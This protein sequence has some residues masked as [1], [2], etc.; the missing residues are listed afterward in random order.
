MAEG[1]KL[2][3]HFPFDDFDKFFDRSRALLQRGLFLGLEL[4]LE[5]LFDASGTKLHRH[6][7]E[8]ILD[9]VLAFQIR[10]LRIDSTISTA[11]DDGA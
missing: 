2:R 6:A 1:R 7:N 9:A 10:S 11:A 8:E 5:D 3:A 4:D